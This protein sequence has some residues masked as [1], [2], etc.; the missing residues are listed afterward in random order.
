L[1]LI[2]LVAVMGLAACSSGG[3]VPASGTGKVKVVAAFYPLAEIVAR[4]GGDRVAVTNLT[5]SGQEPHDLNLSAK[6]TAA[7]LS[8]DLAV[9][10][11]HGFQPSPERVAKER[12]GAVLTILDELPIDAAGKTVSETDESGLDPHV[13]LD[14]A[15]FAQMAGAV[16][17]ALANR[18]PAGAAD[19]MTRSAAYRQQIDAVDA[20]YRGALQSCTRHT[21]VTGHAAFGWLA[22][23][24]GLTQDAISGFS[25]DAAPSAKHLSD[26]AALVR[27]DGVTTIFTETL[28][29]PKVA[30]TLASEAG[31]TTAV[32]NPIEGLTAKEVDQ[33]LDWA[34]VMT[35][36]LAAL[37][38]AL[39]CN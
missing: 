26:L 21:I 10:M 36:N 13:W 22:K 20:A 24:Y 37:R 1:A 2:A 31:V 6:Q 25:P 23:R 4:V 30:K 38:T 19:Y 28:A 3:Q 16:A 27:R 17:V 33:H 12:S 18:D 11:G 34:G 15:L 14:P 32:L 7:L 5:R 9:V 29:S 8:A 35:S 39:G